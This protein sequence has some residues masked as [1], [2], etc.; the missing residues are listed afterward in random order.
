MRRTPEQFTKTTYDLLVIGAGITGSAIAWDASLRGL[1]VALVERGDFGQATSANSMKTVHGGLRYLQDVNLRLV[2]KMIHERRALMRIAPHLVHPLPFMMPTTPITKKLMRSRPLMWTAMK[3]NDILSFDRNQGLDPQQQ[4]PDGRILNRQACIDMLPGLAASSITGAI[5]WYDAQIYNTER[6]L[7]AFVLSAKQAGADVANYMQVESLMQEG[8]TIVGAKARDLITGDEIEIQAK[9]VVNAAGAWVDGLL[10]K[11][12]L[13]ECHFNLS[14]AVNLMIRKTF[15]DHGVALQS[16]LETANGERISNTLVFVPW[17]DCSIVGTFHLPYN[18]HPDEFRLTED[19]IQMFL[20]EANSAYP[21]LDLTHNDIAFIHKGFLPM[22]D[23]PGNQVTL[24][25]EGQVTDHQQHNG[26]AGLLT[27]VGVKWTTGRDLAQ[28]TVDLVLRKLGWLATATMTDQTPLVGG[29]II[30]F[31]DYVNH[32]VASNRNLSSALMRHLIHNYG[33]EY[34]CI[35]DLLERESQLATP[36]PGVAN[37]IAGEVIHAVREEM[38][39]KLSDVIMRRI[40][41]GSA[42]YPDDETVHA[43][44]D[45]MARELHWT[46]DQKTQE[47][48][49]LR[50]RYAPE[51]G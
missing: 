18:G 36:L 49:Q 43:V 44:A 30:N 39:F 23:T 20:N 26:I 40:E 48:N 45:L 11:I 31:H 32:A 25:R 28:R 47:I 22:E 3:L 46:T 38:A 15:S 12:N 27:A 29:Q 42:G 4:L 51:G 14:V 5:V 24:V 6:M 7:L 35:L 41:L 16:R 50:M 33:S 8:N 1:R 2:R 17:R 10:N 34:Q 37:V 9:M 13:H 19:Q 21:S